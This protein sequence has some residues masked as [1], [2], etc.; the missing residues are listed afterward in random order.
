MNKMQSMVHQALSENEPKSLDCLARATGLR[1]G[2]VFR[3]LISLQLMGRAR[4]KV[5]GRVSH[6]VSAHAPKPE[7]VPKAETSVDF[8]RR[9]QP[10]SVW[11]LGDMRGAA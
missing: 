2:A 11:A 5:V 1:R 6:F 8:A 7:A 10:S 4:A 3:A 9:T